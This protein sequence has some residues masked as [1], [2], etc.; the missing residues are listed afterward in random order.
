MI[1]ATANGA[2]WPVARRVPR[3]VAPYV[4]PVGQRLTRHALGLS[5]KWLGSPQIAPCLH[6]CCPLYRGV[7]YLC[8]DAS[9]SPSDTTIS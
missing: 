9:E 2:P 1:I 4:P 8:S 6:V 5:D 7:T 3:S